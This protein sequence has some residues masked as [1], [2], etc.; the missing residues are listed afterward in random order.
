MSVIE[1]QTAT[2]TWQVDKVHSTAGF[3]VKHMVVST[4]RGGFEDFDATLT[5]ED[6]EPRLTGTVRAD[7]IEVRDENL[8]AHLQSPE[9][10]DSE[11]HPEIRFESVAVR[12][13][14]QELAVEGDLTIKGVTKRVEGRGSIVDP[15]ED[16]YGGTRL[17][18]ELTTVVDR[19]EYGLEWNQPLPKGGFA[20]ADDVKLVVNLEFVK[21][22]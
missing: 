19:T 2:G 1:Q 21:A 3:E 16:A 7:S 18:V 14:G 10:F 8:A 20:L 22:E 4:F 11:Q 12:R 17:G 6:G 9:F 5:F 15:H 13:D